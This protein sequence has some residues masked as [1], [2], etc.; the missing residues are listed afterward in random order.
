MNTYL[1]LVPILLPLLGGIFLGFLKAG[2]RR[3]LRNGFVAVITILTFVSVIVCAVNDMPELQ[4]WNLTD[5]I[6]IMLHLDDLGKLISVL[7][8]FLWVCNVF[9]SFEYMKH[10]KREDFYFSC[11]LIALAGMI[12]ITYAGNLV[13]MYLFFEVMAFSTFPLVLHELTKE[14]IDAGKKYL[15]YS[16]AGAFMG[17][18]S[19]F[20]LAHF[21][22]TLSFVPGGSL[23]MTLV[24]EN[25]TLLLVVVFLAIIGFGSKAGMFP[26]HGWL[27]TAHPVAPAP[28][29]ALLSGNITKMGLFVIVRIIYYLVGADFIR[30]TWVQYSFIG[31]ALLT[32]LMGSMMAYKEQILKKRLAY[33]TVSQVSYALLG[34]ALLEPVAL[35]GALMHVVFHSLVKN[36]LFL[37]AGAIIYKRGKKKVGE[38]VGI[39]K[40]MPVTMW[41]FTLVSLTLVG[42]PPTSA[43]LSK[44]Y[45]AIGSLNTGIPVL[46]WLG[47]VTLLMSALLT[48]GYL[49]TITMKGFFPGVDYYEKPIQKTEANAWMLVPMLILTS[50]AVLFGMFPQT[51]IHFI[52]TIVSTVL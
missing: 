1:L 16:L 27:P 5:E 29:S 50:G 7:T 44:W 22:E 48:A 24:S 39:G 41:C 3:G 26:L 31:L 45:L 15:F 28:A 20:V 12:G 23:N 8:S 35:T 37:A 33:S 4:L 25:E 34:I 6:P 17:L 14:S 19:F 10:E 40:E 32:V 47:P 30:G 9:Y 11:V 38:L 42:I 52:E 13:T 49:I 2:N 36:T 21:C 51:L 43:F 18:S 46:S